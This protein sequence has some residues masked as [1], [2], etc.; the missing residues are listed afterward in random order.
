M[1]AGFRMEGVR[2]QVVAVGEGAYEDLVGYGRLTTDEVDGPYGF[3]AVMNTALPRKRVIAHV[4]M[5][6]HQGRV[7]LCET[8]FKSDW[9]LPG[10]IVEVGEPPRLGAIREV[11][12]ELGSKRPLGPLLLVDWMPPYL[13]WEDALEMIFDG[14]VV[15]EAELAGFTLQPSEIKSVQLCTLAEAAALV[16]PIAHRRLTLAASL[17]PGQLAYTE[18]GRVL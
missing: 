1:R 3:S 9:E 18:D 8:Q 11:E 16:T 4:L 10:G 6:D 13:G 5:R 2:R 15:T 12:E 17:A 7:L 14:G